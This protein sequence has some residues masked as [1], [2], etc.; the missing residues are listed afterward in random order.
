M[1]TDILSKNKGSPTCT[2]PHHSDC[3]QDLSRLQ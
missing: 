1:N 3:I 2:C